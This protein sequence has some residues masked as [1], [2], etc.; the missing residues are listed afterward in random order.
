MTSGQK[1]IL[2]IIFFERM[3]FRFFI[4]IL[5]LSASLFGLALPYYQKHFTAHLDL[6]SL[7]ISLGLSLF[8]LILNQMTLFLGQ[9]ESVKAQKKLAQTIYSHDLGLKPLTLQNRTV[10]EIVSLYSTDIPSITVWL[11]QS[12]PYG[13]TTIFPLILTP[14]FLYF[15]YQLPLSFSFGLVMVL[16]LIN[17]AMAY[18]QSLFFFKFKK[19][20]ADRMGL[21]NEWIQNIRG[22]KI[23]NWIEGFETKIIK[24]RREETVNRVSMVTNGQ[25][26]NSIS[27]SMNYWLNLAILGFFIWLTD[28]TIQKTDLVALLW[29]T[30][31]FLTRP[32]RQLPW[33]FT[34]VF[35]AW[36]SYKRLGEFL[37]LK[38]E[39]AQIQSTEATQSNVL[40]QIENLNL[41]VHQQSILHHVNLEIYPHEIVAL[42]GPVGSGKTLLMKSLIQET[43]FTA[44]RFYK[45][46]TS[47]V[48]QDHF[49]M[50][51]TLRDNVA[52]DYNSPQ[53]ND[54]TVLDHLKKA[55]FD[56][57]LDRVQNGLETFIGERGLNLSGGQKQRVSLAR[58]I[59]KPQKLLL[60]DD[61]MSAVDTATEKK[62]MAEFI[63]LKNQGHSILMTTQR[64][65][66]LNQCD[67]I[68]F[69]DHG[70][71]KYAGPS[72]PFL[73]DPQ[74]QS[75]L[76]GLV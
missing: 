47:Y 51:A 15:S 73:S 5:S 72:A 27:S 21:V 3:P 22:L 13:L 18:R 41:T 1:K 40:L 76:K 20:A 2:K 30:T 16:I 49:V 12:L 55:Q 60:L 53:N 11:E 23:L 68:F 56:F 33:F 67:R 66:M 75:F 48:P 39:P 70:I 58:Q 69:L 31:V 52:F 34:F 59:L 14:F 63:H 24:K 7:S 71:I 9:H 8:Y 65:T 6:E 4:L 64:F 26:M 43:P 42:I 29:I 50:S 35:D 28:R 32:L 17:G 25:I 37:D 54:P 46:Q 38:N 74:Y 19:L 44:D 57:E 62:L 61:P 45:N 36:T 10:G